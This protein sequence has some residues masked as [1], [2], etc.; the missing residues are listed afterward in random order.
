MLPVDRSLLSAMVSSEAMADARERALET[1]SIVSVG[2]TK[3]IIRYANQKFCTVMGFHREELIGQSYRILSSQHHDPEFFDDMRAVVNDGE[4]WIGEVCNRAKNGSLLWFDNVIVPLFDENG[5][6]TG[7]F[8]LQKDITQRKIAEER[9][10]RS[11]QFQLDIAAL[12]HIGGWSLNL[13]TGELYWSDETKR[14]HDVPLDYEPQVSEG[15]N[16]YAPEA[17]SAITHAIETAINDGTSWD[18]ELPLITAKG[19]SIWTRAVG[20]AVQDE[21]GN[22]ITLIGAFQDITERKLAEDVLRDEVSQRHSTEQLLRDVLET[23]PDAV[24]AYDPDDR[25][26]IC[27]SAYLE[28]YAASADAIVP[29]ATFESILRCGLERGQYSDVGPDTESQEAWLK[30][31]LIHHKNPPEQLTQRLRSGTWL[32]V[33]EHRSPTGTTVGVRTDITTL[34]RAE[35]ELRKLAETDQLTG[36]FN[37]HSFRLALDALLEELKEGGRTGACVALF[38][39]DH[40]KPINDA[41]GHNVGDDVLAEIANRLTDVLGPD[42]LVARLGGDEFVFVLVDRHDR[43]SN[44][45]EI[46]AFFE[47]M[48]KPIDTRAGLIIADVSLGLVEIKDASIPSRRLLK[49][50]DLAQYRAKHEGRGRWHWFAD[51]DIDK[52]NRESELSQALA[53]SLRSTENLSFGLLPMV[54]SQ[55]AEPLGFSGEVSWAHQGQIYNSNDLRVLVQKT[56]Q[57]PTLYAKAMEVAMASIGDA[58]SRGVEAGQLWLTAGTNH[59]KL[60]PFVGTLESMRERFGLDA[61]AITIAVEEAAL[62]DRSSGVIDKTFKEL[63]LLGYRVAVDRFGSVASSLARLQRLN[64]HAVRLDRKL[65][66]RLID[67]DADDRVVRGLIAMASSVGIEVLAGGVDSPH[68]AARLAS[69]GCA[70]LQGPLIGPTLSGE[71]LSTYL[72]DEARRKLASLLPERALLNTQEEDAA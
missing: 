5:D 20:H 47:A 15:I 50:A 27:N 44:E 19:R 33:R 25:L 9:L 49:Y 65:T 63:G 40:F 70:A 71:D 31:R 66:D 39:I 4:S 58:Q 67:A 12:A 46:I 22:S 48:R 24:A 64:V 2:D 1:H 6:V 57:G 21:N 53:A 7:H 55:T 38:D 62:T 35:D 52:L 32:Q 45:Q 60:E 16:F 11:E 54:A 37:R 41:Y 34:K 72:A 69:L 3:G 17:R 59:I 14:I 23:I 28:T 8:N 26:I 56:G 36:L 42:D 18:L 29:G 10:Q 30:E 61:S 13:K 43:Q 68:H 51:D